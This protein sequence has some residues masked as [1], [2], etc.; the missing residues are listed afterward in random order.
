M[1]RSLGFVMAAL[2]GLV[3]AGLGGCGDDGTSTPT[4]PYFRF[5]LPG[6][7]TAAIPMAELPYPNDALRGADGRIQVT[8]DSFAHSPD[9]DPGVVATA[10]AALARRRGFGVFTGAIFPVAALAAGETLDPATLT[11]ATVTLVALADGARVPLEIT[12]KPDGSLHLQPRLGHVLAQG[13]PYA[14]VLGAGIKTTRG[15]ALVADPDLTALLTTDQP[16][17]P[18]ARAAV[19]YA[20]LRAYLLAQAIDP[21]TIVGATVFTTADYTPELVAARAILDAQA[22]ATAVIDRVY[23]AGA[24]LDGFLGTPT[25]DD[26]PGVDNPGGI[27]HAH[28]RAMVLGHFA[29]ADFASAAPRTLGA[30]TYDASGA[31]IV[32]GTEDVPFLLALPAS[33]GLQDM[34]IM[35]FNHGFG[36]SRAVVASVANAMAARGIAVIGIDSPSHGERYS[37]ARDLVHNFTGADGADGLADDANAASQLEFLDIIGDP[38]AGIAQ[39]DVQVMSASF[40]QSVVDIMSEVRLVDDGD[41]TA[42]AADFP[43]LS[44]RADRLVYS[45]QSMGGILGSVVT[46]IDPRVGAAV[47]G[48]AGGGLLQHATENS[49]WLWQAFGVVLGGAMG[50]APER[51]DPGVAPPHTDLAFVLMQT[52]IEDADPLTYAPQTIRAPLGAPKHVALLNAFSDEILPN[53]A[54]EALALAMGLEWM[55]TPL[56]APGPRYIEPVAV[57]AAPLTANVTVGATAVTAGWVVLTPAT[58]GMQTN[59]RDESQYDVS[60]PPFHLR[61][62]PLAITNPIVEVQQMTAEF[63]R[64][65]IDTGTPTLVDP[66]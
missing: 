20:P 14:Y 34:P 1:R 5:D 6:D 22:P 35:V 57:R 28:L 38:A 27:A 36:G 21:A 12:A 15:A 60:F 52:L 59:H 33:G 8:V 16:S 2:L 10:T 39:L 56:S 45:G 17:G 7:P 53:Q 54:S 58:H 65:Y 11:D 13:A 44:F 41:W 49:P 66:F 37:R 3:S 50:V 32:K 47:L 55:T 29:A 63:A 48:V 61:A 30:W 31:P 42:L 4:G 40:R 24:E 25:D 62:A 23:R 43:G 19:A 18:A 46:T 26:F 64:T 9:A 51:A